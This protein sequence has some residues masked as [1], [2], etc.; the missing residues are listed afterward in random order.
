MKMYTIGR[1]K[2]VQ[3]FPRGEW[4][5]E[6]PF[7]T[8][9][10]FGSDQG[11]EWW[12]ESMCGSGRQCDSLASAQQ[13]AQEHFEKRMEEGLVEVPKCE[14]CNDWAVTTDCKGVPLCRSCFDSLDPD[15]C[16][17]PKHRPSTPATQGERHG[18]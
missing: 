16:D 14:G 2:W 10:A 9:C 1:L 8:F 13:A 3:H 11:G 12:V 6:T 5:A 7:G 4:R 17:C 15:D 18:E